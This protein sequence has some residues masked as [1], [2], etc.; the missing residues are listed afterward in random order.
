MWPF[1]TKRTEKEI[2]K[3]RTKNLQAMLRSAEETQ[4]RESI[5]TG[6]VKLFFKEN[7]KNYSIGNFDL[8][9]DV[10]ISYFFL[11]DSSNEKCTELIYEGKL[12]NLTER[13]SFNPYSKTASFNIYGIR[14]DM[15]KARI[16]LMMEDSKGQIYII[17]D[18]CQKTNSLVRAYDFTTF[19][20]D[21][22][23]ISFVRHTLAEIN[24]MNKKDTI[25]KLK[26]LTTGLTP[27]EIKEALN[28]K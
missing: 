16:G 24:Q 6:E 28:I 15:G 2:Q 14:L 26:V 20:R 8:N 1:N 5:E 19:E 11:K 22:V 4:I 3:S 13:E 27:E 18:R 7:P 23:S 12:H 17:E 21:C 10:K 25:K 9:N